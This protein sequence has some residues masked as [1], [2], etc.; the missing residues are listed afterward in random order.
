MPAAAVML[1]IK[2]V[3]AEKGKKV[4]NVFIQIHK[5]N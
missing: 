4:K 1:R 3:N 5:N 2:A